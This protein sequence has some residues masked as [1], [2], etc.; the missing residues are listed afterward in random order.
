[1][2]NYLAGIFDS[3]GYVRIRKT[4]KYSGNEYHYIPEVRLYMTNKQ[5]VSKFAKLYG[6]AVKTEQRG[7]HLKRVYHTSIGIG[8]LRATQFLN[9]FL[10]LLNEK[11]LQ[12][13]EVY[14]IV[15][16]NKDKEECYQ[17]YVKAKKDF[18]HPIQSKNITNE[19]LAGII[20]GDGW[21]S[22]F[23]GGKGSSMY[24]QVNIGLQQRYKPMVEYVA[25]IL[26]KNVHQCKIYDYQ[27]HIQTWSTNSYISSL[28]TLEFLK[29]ICPYLIEK[30]K[31]CKL[32]INYIKIY[33]KFKQLSIDTLAKFKLLK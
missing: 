3:E 10:P 24:N 30:K 17:R 6:L 2:I 20:D 16:T 7:S 8:K 28:T 12:L 5:I 18:T 21:I 14:N 13:Q 25:N 22:L 31:K 9:D 23:N 1:M 33:D 32:V 29:D 11:K 4:K 15:H 27:S 19:Y 26:H